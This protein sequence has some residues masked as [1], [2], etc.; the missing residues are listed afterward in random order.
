M[1]WKLIFQLSLFG[2]AMA[3]ATVYWIPSNLEPVFWLV[4]A[5]LCAYL[6]ARNCIQK[7]FLHGF[8]VSL[9][10]CVWITAIHV[11]LFNSYI[12][13]HP[14]EADMMEKMPLPEHPRVM[15]LIIGPIVGII[16]GLIFGL[17]AFIASKIWKNRLT[18]A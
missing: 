14:K 10:N 7:Y 2:L 11:L 1:N 18:Q 12:V 8:L 15:M 4:I 9:V 3:I 13:N 17:F 16:S 6:I 5:I